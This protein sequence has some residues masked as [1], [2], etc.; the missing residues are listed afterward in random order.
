MMDETAADFWEAVTTASGMTQANIIVGRLESEG[1]PTK[2][3]YDAAGAI[4]AVTIDGLGEVRILVPV[5][6][7]EKAKEIL[8]RSYDEGDLLWE[9]NTGDPPGGTGGQGG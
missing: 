5:N 6:D 8:S 4:Y 9:R 2:L 1:I 3:Y 7:W